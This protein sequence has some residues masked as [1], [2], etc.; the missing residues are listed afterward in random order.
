MYKELVRTLI[1]A[2][3]QDVSLYQAEVEAFGGNPVNG[4][5][6]AKLFLRLAD[7]ELKHLKALGEITNENTGFRHR[8][9]DPPRS[10]QAALRAHTDREASSIVMYRALL[11]LM[12]KP[13]ALETIKSII[14]AERAHLAAIREFQAQIKK[15]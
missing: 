11:K 1:N 14:L 6:L 12:K 7:E 4:A 2:E 9:T 3:M 8:N 13:E 5:K 15:A 10:I